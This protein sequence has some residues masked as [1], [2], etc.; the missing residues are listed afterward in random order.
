M[1]N[2]YNK[3]K[4]LIQVFTFFAIL[5]IFIACL[6]I[7]GLAAFT[8]ERRTKEIGLRKVMGAG[9]PDIVRLLM[10]QFTKPVLLANLLAWPAAAYFLNDWLAGF[11]QRIDLNLVWFIVAG[12]SALFIAW[13]TVASH[14]ARV[15]RTSPIQALRYE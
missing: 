9:P 1:E 7:Y 15:A 3:E 4:K 8:A 14:A 12:A 13:A 10:W 2:Q 5:A 6:G 11:Q